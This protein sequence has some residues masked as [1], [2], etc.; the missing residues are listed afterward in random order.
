MSRNSYKKMIVLAAAVVLISAGFAR[1]DKLSL[2][3]KI[4]K[5]VRIQLSDVTIAE[6]LEKI[7]QKAGVKIVLSD[8][9]VWKL[10]YGKATRMAVALQGPFAESLDEMLDTFF[11]R[12]AVGEEEITIYPRQELEHILGRPTAKQLE[13]LRDI[14]TAPIGVY[15][16]GQE[17]RSINEAIGRPILIS[18]MSVLGQ[19]DNLFRQLVGQESITTR[20]PRTRSSR[21]TVKERQAPEPNEA[22]PIELPT[23]VTLAQLL[24][25]VEA[26]R[27]SAQETRWYISG[28]DFPGHTPEICVVD[29]SELRSLQRKQKID[30]SYENER[31]DKILRDLANRGK[32]ELYINPNVSLEKNIISMSMENVTPVEAIKNICDMTGLIYSYDNYYIKI[33]GFRKK[34]SEQVK[35]T[36]SRRK[37]SGDYIGKISVPMD[38]GKYFVEFMLRE[39]DLT[40]ELRKLRA[41]KMTEVLGEAPKQTAKPEK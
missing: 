25:Q 38:G 35:S 19:I 1:A 7:G 33:E 5:E 14:Y 29:F 6:A 12:Y 21:V 31:A 22:E 8:E 30:V 9:A 18:P 26:D 27:A 16:F 23:P 13:L 11:M 40:D 34:D 17:Q 15:Y 41:E 32:Y 10:P 37:E 2:Q 36:P 3:G 4:S 24:R 28:M 39:S 20:Q